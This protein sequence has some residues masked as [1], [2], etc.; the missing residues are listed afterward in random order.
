M[1]WHT[2]PPPASFVATYSSS[3]GVG[4]TRLV[5]RRTPP[6]PALVSRV[7]CCDV[8]LLLRRW[9]HASG[10][11]TYP[12]SHVKS[13][14]LLALVGNPWHETQPIGYSCEVLHSNNLTAQSKG[15]SISDQ[16]L[17][18]TKTH[19]Y[20][21]SYLALISKTSSNKHF[22]R[23]LFVTCNTSLRYELLFVV[24]EVRWCGI[25]TATSAMIA[26]SECPSN[27]RARFLS[28]KR[29]RDVFAVLRWNC[30]NRHH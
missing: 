13:T 24:Y 9:F 21:F 15:G 28:N 22:A 11:A 16:L 25:C 29:A 2:P 30:F 19:L 3:S 6:P 17:S 7:L 5:L 18:K 26:F 8:P 1:L 12:F 23:R 20:F 4:F 14:R 27:W 10:V